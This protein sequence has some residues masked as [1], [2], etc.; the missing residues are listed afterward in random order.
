MIGE[1]FSRLLE[2][3]KHDHTHT[4]FCYES[5]SPS[6]QV[7]NAQF[8]NRLNLERKVICYLNRNPVSKGSKE[9]RASERQHKCTK[10]ENS[11]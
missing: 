2:A 7:K 11:E 6:R 3:C 9:K 10:N 1:Y 5:M 8:N 4:T